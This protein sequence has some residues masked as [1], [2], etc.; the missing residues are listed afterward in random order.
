MAKR[1]KKRGR[2]PDR[3]A[4][5]RRAAAKPG[6]LPTLWA[7]HGRTLRAWAVLLFS[8]AVLVKLVSLDD[9]WLEDAAVR[10]T[11]KL[12]AGALALL[13][14][15]GRAD[16]GLVTSTIFSAQIIPECTGV[17][18]TLLLV[19]AVLAYPCGWR[20]KLL[21]IALGVPTMMFINVVRLV[22]LFYVGYWRPDVFE[23]A[24]LVVWQSLMI[25]FTVAV[26]L[27]WAAFWVGRGS[28]PRPA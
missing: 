14:Q 1:D 27:G 8:Y 4:P 3:G 7:R 25:F 6:P 2:R 9:S 21:G 23:A 28:E 5:R 18:P 11:A 17:F 13:G 20:D 12:T 22:T 10:A 26:W 15:A 19:A 16:G 24:H